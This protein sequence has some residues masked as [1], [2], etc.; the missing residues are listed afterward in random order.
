MDAWTIDDAVALLHP[1]MT[2]AEVRAMLDLIGITAVGT[3]RTACVCAARAQ[4][5]VEQSA[6]SGHSRVAAAP[7]R[8][9]SPARVATFLDAD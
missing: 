2:A 8:C 5:E 4:V 6:L 9:M 3:R 1:V 7:Q